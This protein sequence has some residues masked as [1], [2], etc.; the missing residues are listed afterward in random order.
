LSCVLQVPDEV[1]G[2]LGNVRGEAR[3]GEAEAEDNARRGVPYSQFR[4]LAEQ[5]Y[6]G[7]G[8]QRQRYRYRQLITPFHRSAAM[9]SCGCD[10][11]MSPIQPRTRCGSKAETVRD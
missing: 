4:V 7:P 2:E 1:L 9:M 3:R 8:Q 10:V 11:F 5:E 6:H